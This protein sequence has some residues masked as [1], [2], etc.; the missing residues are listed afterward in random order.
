MKSLVKSLFA[1]AKTGTQRYSE[2]RG[3]SN[4]VPKGLEFCKGATERYAFRCI[5]I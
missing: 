3:F 2:L 1:R 4:A 5:C